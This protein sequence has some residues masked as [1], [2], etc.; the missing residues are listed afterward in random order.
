MAETTF[1]QLIEEITRRFGE[2]RERVASAAGTTT[3]LVDTVGLY[4]PDDYWVGH[5]LRMTSGTL[6]GQERPIVDYSQE[7]GT[8]TVAPAFTAPTS[9]TDDYQI[10][11]V[12]RVDAEAS[13]NAGIRAAGL[14]WP[15]LKVDTTT[16]PFS[17]TSYEYD[18]PTDLSALIGVLARHA[19]TVPWVPLPQGTWAVSGTPGAQKLQILPQLPMPAGATVRVD[20]IARP[21]E[22]TADA[23]TLGIGEPAEADAVTFIHY[24]GLYWLHD[25]AA[26]TEP[27]G[28]AFRPHL[29]QA[30]YYKELAEMH[31]ARTAQWPPQQQEE[32]E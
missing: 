20:Y 31:R 5:Y 19:A 6:S 14:S 13:V 18:L 1:A 30:Q 32:A 8:I 9:A 11:P 22:M 12:R 26:S 3:T 4:E 27:T 28:A 24:Y 23:N 16:G 2:Y 17:G 29:T 7:T 10:M 15:V 21:S 25:K